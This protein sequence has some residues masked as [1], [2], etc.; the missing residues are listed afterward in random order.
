MNQRPAPAATP[1]PQVAAPPQQP[2]QGGGQGWGGPEPAP[3]TIP[4]E[5]DPMQD[6]RYLPEQW[7]G[8]FTNWLYPQKAR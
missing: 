4:Q 8:A 3:G 7:R 5:Y 1:R 2:A 6:P